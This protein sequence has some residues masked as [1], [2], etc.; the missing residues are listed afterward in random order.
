[1]T[2]TLEFDSIIVPMQSMIEF[3]QDYEDIKA[4]DFRRTADGAGHLRALT[5]SKLRTTISGSG[6][7]P[8]AFAGLSAGATYTIKCATPRSANSATTSVTLPAARRTDGDHTPI[9][10]ALVGIELIET[11]I[12]GIVANVATLTSVSGASGYRVH[13]WPQISA[14]ITSMK[15]RGG[16]AANF[17]FSIEAEE[18]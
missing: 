5:W 11:P 4:E 13:Y 14:V 15:G 16:S 9:G 1:M 10:F 18:V 3:D 7:V 6:W 8:T 2:F 17:D 12:T